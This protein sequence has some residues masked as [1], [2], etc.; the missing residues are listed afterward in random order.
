[1]VDARQ[2]HALRPVL[3]HERRMRT[4]NRDFEC[5]PAVPGCRRQCDDPRLRID[6]VR[7]RHRAG[8]RCGSHVSLR[9]TTVIMRADYDLLQGVATPGPRRPRHHRRR[10]HHQVLSSTS[11]TSGEGAAS[12]QP[13]FLCAISSFRVIISA[14]WLQCH[15]TKKPHR[16]HNPSGAIKS[17]RPILVFDRCERHCPDQ[18]SSGAG[19]CGP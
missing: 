5:V 13:L 6:D 14:L 17:C 16:W 3:R 2:D 15:M 4:H 10:R 12:G 7:R 1:M 8:Y 9:R 11:S 18:E 19:F